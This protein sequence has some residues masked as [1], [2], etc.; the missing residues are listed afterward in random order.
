MRDSCFTRLLFNGCDHQLRFN[1]DFRGKLDGRL[2]LE[3][4]WEGMGYLPG[5]GSLHHSRPGAVLILREQPAPLLV[6]G[7]S[8]VLASL[9]LSVRI[10]IVTLLGQVWDL[11]LF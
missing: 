7:G 8:I 1:R 2:H 4:I 6:C 5:E 3:Q 11:D 9:D 10:G